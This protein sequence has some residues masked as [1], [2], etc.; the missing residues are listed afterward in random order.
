[1]ENNEKELNKQASE[2]IVYETVNEAAEN[3]APKKKSTVPFIIF[4]LLAVI[5]LVIVFF[6]F[7]GIS[8]SDILDNENVPSEPE[9]IQ[10]G[11][12]DYSATD[13]ELSE[14]KELNA[15][16]EDYVNTNY[17]SK[18]IASSYGFLYS[19]VSKNN[20]MLKD[21][22]SEGLFKASENVAANTDILYM[23]AA[24]IGLSGNDFKVCTAFNTKDGYYFSANGLEG[25]Y[26]S[27]QEYHD[28]VLKYSF[29]HGSIINPKKGDANYQK[30]TAAAAIDDSYDIK[31]LACDDKY[32][33]V[34]ANKINNTSEF[35][36]V[37][38][39][40]EGESWK[41]GIGNAANAKNS[42]QTVNKQFP[43]MELGLLPIYNIGDYPAILSDM[44][45]FTQQLIDLGV[46]TKDEAKNMYT[47]SAGNFAYFQTENG[48]RLLG[49]MENGKLEFN[50]M[51]S[52]EQTISA[53]VNAEPDPPVFIIKFN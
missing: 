7:K 38:L 4:G 44:P 19:T 29:I 6:I 32:A 23:K 8:N 5:A 18:G 17:E 9:E 25:R 15:V 45:E 39:V 36:E 37:I 34:V 50:K 22:M 27:E 52:L 11:L 46:I 53:M 30:I 48:K 1:M 49:H 43:D 13:A 20:I 3:E 24:D 40:K 35:S 28:L 10:V 42:K 14:L 12:T 47:C 33:V 31:H 16:L 51:Q 26:Y 41:V 21:I 2:E